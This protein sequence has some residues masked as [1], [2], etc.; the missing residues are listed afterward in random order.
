MS[1]QT[2]SDSAIMVELDKATKLEAELKALISSDSNS[3]SKSSEIR[4]KLCEVFSDVLLT[5]CTAALRKDVTTR[6]WYSCFY[7]RIQELRQRIAKEKNRAKKQSL[8][9]DVDETGRNR[10]QLAEQSLKKFIQEG[11]TLYNFLVDRLQGSLLPPE[12]TQSQS[13]YSEHSQP[14]SKGTVPALH[15]LYIHLGDMHRYASSFTEAEHAYLQASKL[16]PSKGNPYNQMA[17]VAQ[18]KETNGYPLPAMALYWY[19]RSLSSYEVFET[20]KG[21]IERLFA[22][23]EKWLMKN[24]SSFDSS[25]S[26]LQES[27]QGANRED[28][29][30]IKG[31]ASRMVLSRFVSYHGSLY[32]KK[33][34]NLEED[35]LLQRYSEVL[36]VNPFGD[37]LMTKLVVINIFSAWN[38][39]HYGD[40][41]DIAFQFLVKFTSHICQSIEYNLEKTYTKLEK[42]G[43]VTNIRLLGPLLLACE[44]ISHEILTRSSVKNVAKTVPC[45]QEIC[46]E[47]WKNVAKI[48]TE[49]SALRD[50]SDDLKK[51]EV[52]TKTLPEDFISLSRG[53][54][55]FSF[56]STSQ[57]KASD[58]AYI[59][60]DEA[61]EAL[62][63]SVSHTQSQA[64]QRCTKQDKSEDSG[65]GETAIKVARFMAFVNRHI[66]SGDLVK[67]DD[68]C[69]EASC[70]IMGD[71]DLEKKSSHSSAAIDVSSPPTEDRDILVY[72]QGGK[73][74]PA[75]LVPSALL[76]GIPADEE[77]EEEDVQMD[78]GS[79][80]LKLSEIIDKN[81]KEKEAPVDPLD[82]LDMNRGNEVVEVPPPP[83]FHGPYTIPQTTVCST[84][85]PLM[86]TSKNEGLDT[87]ENLSTEKYVFGRMSSY[88]N[89]PSPS[90]LQHAQG[91][92]PMFNQSIIPSYEIPETRNPFVS[93][94]T[95]SYGIST[96]NDN[97]SA[98]LNA[99]SLGD[100]GSYLDS[101]NIDEHGI[102]GHDPFGLRALG[103]FS[104]DEKPP[105]NDSFS[106]Q[107]KVETKNPFYLG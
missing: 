100:Y 44:F 3:E 11:I 43:K 87:N 101:D 62:G 103:I 25:S 77:E 47:F 46:D 83:G 29:K 30:Q 32:Q 61:I 16:A 69:I 8:T 40:V 58:W 51:V 56:L 97:K 54:I 28:S 42:T 45:C 64:S 86:T 2:S 92:Q 26:S 80:L 74:K 82:G 102:N 21:N 7:N 65:D 60:Q 37:G 17:V 50:L 20:S 49:L 36:D 89:R 5:D 85:Q 41:A 39:Q 10:I 59:D 12:E 1:S 107:N 78:D 73:G 4:I 14:F 22:A 70:L 31:T 13:Q 71:R 95:A 106:F 52:D 34:H 63:L 75:L 68:G 94:L 90:T 15:K 96:T 99:R 23:N 9:G 104:A 66:E 81:M 27:L 38:A 6:L 76:T 19:C 72:K 53:C 55:P 57:R 33:I 79:D 18:L 98:F 88:S 48:A 67:T 93:R 84:S 35:L 24:S 91:P 105:L